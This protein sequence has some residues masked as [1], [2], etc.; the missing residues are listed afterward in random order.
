MQA[1]LPGWRPGICSEILTGRTRASGIGCRLD[2]AAVEA[3][4]DHVIVAQLP[5]PLL[6]I[7]LP[8]GLLH[9]GASWHV[10]KS[11]TQS[12]DLVVGE[13][14]PWRVPVAFGDEQLHGLEPLLPLRIVP[15]AHTDEAVTVLREKLFRALLAWLEM[16]PDP[17]G[18]R[19]R[20]APG[21]RCAS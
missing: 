19:L 20:R 7:P 5:D 18:G 10:G 12:D 8:S 3:E 11:D 6:W 15:I 14:R 17:R 4:R 16:Q 1:S 21:R 13:A 2:N 9:A